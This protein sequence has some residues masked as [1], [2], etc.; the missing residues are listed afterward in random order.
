[1][2][3]RIR[4]ARGEDSFTKE[5]LDHFS[6]QYDAQIRTLDENLRMLISQ[7]KQR[8]QFDDLLILITSDHGEYLGE[9]DLVSHGSGL[10]NELLRVPLM[11][12]YPQRQ[13][14]GTETDL[15]SIVQIPAI[16]LEALPWESVV[17][18]PAHRARVEAI[19]ERHELIP[20]NRFFISEAHFDSSHP[21]ERR[22]DGYAVHGGRFKF[23]SSRWRGEELYDLANDPDETSNILANHPGV[24]HRLR[25]ILRTYKRTVMEQTGD[26][27]VLE[28]K[29]NVEAL[30][31]LGYLQ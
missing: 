13:F 30:R 7:L 17:V 22:P 19:L 8:G 29:E 15:T 4:A 10:F 31:A 14:V 16:V 9:H 21:G 5:E 27:A 20:K 25:G 12:R 23:I 24:A 1:L 6:S 18:D 2:R 28:S 26:G 3:H 11:I